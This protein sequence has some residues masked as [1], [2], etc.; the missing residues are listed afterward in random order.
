[1]KG[2]LL[3]IFELLHQS[4]GPQHWWP[5]DGPFEVVVG[6]ILT[7][8]TSWKNVEKAIAN[9]KEVGVLSPAKMEALGEERLA[10]L[11]RPSGYYRVKADRL[12]RFLGFLGDRYGFDLQRMLRGPLD[13]IRAE[14]LGVRGIGPETA[15]SI[16][17]YAGGYPIFVVDAYT[18]RIFSRH[19]WVSA[20]SSYQE[21]QGLFTKALPKDVCLFQEFHALLVRLGK[22]CCLRLPQCEGCVLKGLQT[23][24]NESPVSAENASPKSRR[25]REGR[26][27]KKFR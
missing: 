19:G 9:L 12:L 16:L 22:T 2:K 26:T 10:D 17:L 6:A 15:D 1:L 23:G 25:R 20:E 27:W 14:L 18:K 3:R 24:Q 8:N 13:E 5:A 4:Y 7:Q 11:I 21:L